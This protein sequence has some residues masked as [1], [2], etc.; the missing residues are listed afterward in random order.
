[1]PIYLYKCE[2]CEYE[3]EIIQQ[4]GGDGLNCPECG[5]VLHKKPTCHAFVFMKGKGGYPSFRK[6][7]LGTA[8][9]TRKI[10]PS[11]V[12]GGPG[13]KLPEAKIEGEKWLESLE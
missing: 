4:I 1:M 9:Y 7:Y 8:P 10:F 2:Q 5:L 11:E 12:K 3:E 13:S 6:R